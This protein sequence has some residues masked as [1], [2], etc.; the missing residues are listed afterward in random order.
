M[1]IEYSIATPGLVG[2][3]VY[4]ILSRDVATLANERKPAGVYRMILD[5]SRLASGV[6]FYRLS[7]E[8]FVETSKL[9]M[10]Q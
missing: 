3:K 5:G 8:S 9:I 10:L 4:D 6:N 2:L 1:S 7:A